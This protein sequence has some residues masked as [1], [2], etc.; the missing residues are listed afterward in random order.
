MGLMCSMEYIYEYKCE[1]IASFPYS[2]PLYLRARSYHQKVRARAQCIGVFLLFVVSSRIALILNRRRPATHVPLEVV[3]A[4]IYVSLTLS[5]P[6]RVFIWREGAE[7]P[8]VVWSISSKNSND[9]CWPA[10]FLQY[11]IKAKMILHF[12]S[13]IVVRKTD[14]DA[15]GPL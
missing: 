12:F 7:Y 15:T 2:L 1:C 13:G 11:K 5:C 14:I 8:I 9:S 4:R 3:M 6:S 10:L